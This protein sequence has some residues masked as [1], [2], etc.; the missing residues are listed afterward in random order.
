MPCER[1]TIK[2][3]RPSKMD[4][5]AFNAWAEAKFQTLVRK[6]IK[7]S[8]LN[9]VALFRVRQE[10]AYELDVS[11]MTVG[12]YIRKY[13]ASTGPFRLTMHGLSIGLNPRYKKP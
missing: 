12:R 8:G 9:E 6:M 13:C 3:P 2:N 7:G 4:R 10:C 11:V 1:G 5:R